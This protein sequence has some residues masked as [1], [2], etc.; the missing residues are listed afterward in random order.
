MFSHSVLK[1]S[2]THCQKKREGEQ[3]RNPTKR[4]FQI[5]TGKGIKQSWP[6]KK[7]K[8]LFDNCEVF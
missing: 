2:S 3:K 5:K 1:E 8:K 7:K 6:L 4:E